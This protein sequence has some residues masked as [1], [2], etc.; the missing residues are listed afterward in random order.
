MIVYFSTMSIG[1]KPATKRPLLN[2]F[3]TFSVICH[4]LLVVHFFFS[5]LVHRRFVRFYVCCYLPAEFFVILLMN[6]NGFEFSLFQL[7]LFVDFCCV[8][9]IWTVKREDTIFLCVCI[10]IYS[11]CWFF[12]ANVLQ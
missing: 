4:F 6:L 7:E 12:C 8:F 10:H 11:F 5:A 1:T 9:V 3:E 2:S